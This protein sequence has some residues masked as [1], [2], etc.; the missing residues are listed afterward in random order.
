MSPFRRICVFCGSSPGA[1]PDYENA[2]VALGKTLAEAGIGLVYG[3]GKV[4]LMGAIADTV[5]EAGGEVIG[6]IP[7][8]L[9][10]PKVD[11]P[12]ISE[13][14][15]VADM[16]ERKALMYELSD[17]F[18]VLPGGLGTLEEFAEAITWVQIGL[19]D[20]PIGILDV[21]GFYT[22][23]LAFLNH[24]RDEQLIKPANLAALSVHTQPE[25]L[26]T[27]MAAPRPEQPPKWFDL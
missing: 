8:G 18:V 23:L 27:A 9:F 21:A 11:H 17:G 3:G 13:L 26:L 22:N 1:R 24:A 19:H 14:R 20:K 2:A 12:D 15:Y 7:E 16:H 5:M 25:P 6:V 4:G 10:G